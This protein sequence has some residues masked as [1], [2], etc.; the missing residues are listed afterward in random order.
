MTSAEDK[1]LV[2]RRAAL[3]AEAAAVFDA[4]T[5]QRDRAHDDEDGDPGIYYRQQQP[6][7]EA[8]Y[9]RACDAL[10]AFDSEYP[11]ITAALREQEADEVRRRLEFD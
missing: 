8:A 5:D 1:V 4:D 3:A 6:A 11:Q 10:A 2:A 7:N 9:E